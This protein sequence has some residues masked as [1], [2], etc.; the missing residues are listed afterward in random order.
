MLKELQFP[1]LGLQKEQMDIIRR[2]R[3]EII[4]VSQPELWFINNGFD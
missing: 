1:K 2:I 4:G 3:K